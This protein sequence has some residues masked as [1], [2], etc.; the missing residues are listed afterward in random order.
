MSRPEMNRRDFIRGSA[1]AIAAATT[2]PA[3]AAS[4]S[5]AQPGCKVGA[6]YLNAQMYTSVPAQVRADM[7]W[8][9]EKGTDFV[10][11]GV[12]EQDLWAARENLALIISEAE[13]ARMQVLA[14]PSRWGGLTA[15]AP[16][17]PS[18]FS[19]LNPH[20]WMH[21]EQGR[22]GFSPFTS[23][24][25]SS[26]HWP[27]TLQYFRDT[28]TELYRQHP[29]LAGII[30]DEPKAFQIDHSPRARAVLGANASREAHLAA[31]ARFYDEVCGH[32]KQLFPEK[33]TLLFNQ[34]HYRDDEITLCAAM[35]HTDYFGA[36]GRPWDLEA[37][38]RWSGAGE[39]QESGK[40][41]VLLSGKGRK[42]IELAR[43]NGKKA[44]LLIENH[45][46]SAD[47]IEPM[48]RHLPEVLKLG[49]DL[50]LYYYYPRNVGAPDR[51]MEII[52]RNLKALKR[53]PAA[54]IPK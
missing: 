51:T 30:I 21:D 19:V 11:V 43:A 50:Y 32:S 41:K 26:V 31:A 15:G 29:S 13:R 6:Y 27:E 20:T 25:I 42:F 52:G 34:A 49:A 39:N 23:G 45:N 33:L 4:G 47:M 3:V 12:L 40:G 1:V 9:A 8:M 54:K 7:A 14:V 5:S 22:A 46:F 18:M 44:L 2:T 48:E 37:D 35:R 10:C 24:V 16:K 28:L 38:G 53:T 17:V 36:D